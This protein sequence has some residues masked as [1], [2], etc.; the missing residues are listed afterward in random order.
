MRSRTKSTALIVGLFSLLGCAVYPVVIH[1]KF[2]PEKYSNCLCVCTINI[3]LYNIILYIIYIY[4]YRFIY[5][6]IYIIYIYIIMYNYIDGTHTHIM[7]IIYRVMTM[8]EFISSIVFY[9]VL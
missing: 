1:P 2:H 4:I 5:I 9:T 3:I 6:Y 7:Y 8:S